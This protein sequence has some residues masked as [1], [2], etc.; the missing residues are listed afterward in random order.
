M[1][2][3]QRFT[4]FVKESGTPSVDVL[5]YINN[6]IHIINS[7]GVAIDITVLTESDLTVDMVNKLTASGISRFPALVIADNKI[8]LGTQ[9][10]KALFEDNKKTY[11]NWVA[12][13]RQQKTQSHGAPVATD[14]AS[15][16]DFY[17]REMT[18]AAKKRDDGVSK[19]N[20]SF[21]TGGSGE[22]F[23]RRVADQMQRRKLNPNAGAIPE[24][25]FE[26]NERGST[27]P[28]PPRNIGETPNIKKVAPMSASLQAIM[29]DTSLTTPVVSK[30]QSAQ[31][32]PQNHEENALGGAFDD[33]IFD[34]AYTQNLGEF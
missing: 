6:N 2:R 13:Q 5:V 7:M 10:I 30:K 3:I 14:E 34:R 24:H 19:S 4:L 1:Q 8:K 31:Q 28:I 20:E 9:R 22:D 12:S 11:N 26:D 18:L 27:K 32:T 17:Q 16:Q 23:S 33:S 21:E 25:T 29:N 15:L